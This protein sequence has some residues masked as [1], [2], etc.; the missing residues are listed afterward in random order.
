MLHVVHVAACCINS[1]LSSTQG[2]VLKSVGLGTFKVSCSDN[3]APHMTCT[4]QSFTVVFMY[5][6]SYVTLCYAMIWYVNTRRDW[7]DLVCCLC[8]GSQP[9]CSTRRTMPALQGVNGTKAGVMHSN[10]RVLLSVV[11]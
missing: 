10:S 3:T 2:T 8:L 7:S 11:M 9:V 5:N 4:T 6:A 1:R